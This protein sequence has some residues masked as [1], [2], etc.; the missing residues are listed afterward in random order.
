MESGA[1]RSLSSAPRRPDPEAAAGMTTP[2]NSG[3]RTWKGPA[4]PHEGDAGPLTAASTGQDFPRGASPEF[5][6]PRDRAAGTSAARSRSAAGTA[7]SPAPPHQPGRPALVPGPV[8]AGEP[9]AGTARKAG[10]GR[11]SRR[12]APPRKFQAG[13]IVCRLDSPPPSLYIASHQP[14][15]GALRRDAQVAQLVEHATENRSVGGS[16]PPLGTIYLLEIA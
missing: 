16:I 12:R 5:R 15:R 4:L 2:D 6:L 3:A 1:P 10:A 7:P 13:R 8:R 9:A 14:K 11:F